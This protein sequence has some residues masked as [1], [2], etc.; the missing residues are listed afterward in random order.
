MTKLNTAERQRL[1]DLYG[2]GAKPTS[3][4]YRDLIDAI[5]EGIQ[6]HQHRLSGGPGSGTGDASPLFYTHALHDANLH[7]IHAWLRLL[8]THPALAAHIP[9]T[10]WEDT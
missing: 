2:I 3:W 8:T 7:N 4:D 1:Q 5:Q 9:T 6:S 10:T